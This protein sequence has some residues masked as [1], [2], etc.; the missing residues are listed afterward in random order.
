MT[1]GMLPYCMNTDALNKT[2]TIANA[3]TAHEGGFASGTRQTNSNG[4]EHSRGPV[5]DSDHHQD[6]QNHDDQY[7]CVHKSYEPE[8]RDTPYQP[9][10]GDIPCDPEESADIFYEYE[11]DIF[12]EHKNG[13]VPDAYDKCHVGDEAET[14]DPENEADCNDY[15]DP[16]DGIEDELE[17]Y[18]D[19]ADDNEY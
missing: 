18:F 5:N 8:E 14:E 12:F 1:T 7:H 16:E 13:E 2:P 17:V 6:S 15:D 19:Q 11:G 10:E 9:D 4:I 3:N